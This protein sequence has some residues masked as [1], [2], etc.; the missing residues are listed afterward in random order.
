MVFFLN[1]KCVLISDSVD[2]CCKII[3]EVNGIVVDFKMKFIKEEFFV[4]IF[5]GYEI[6]FDK[7]VM[8]RFFLFILFF[9]FRIMMV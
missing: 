7:F 2:N 6:N 3:L 4:E 5:V 1:F 9:I 8:Y